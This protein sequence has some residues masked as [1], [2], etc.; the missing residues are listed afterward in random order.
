MAINGIEQKVIDIFKRVHQCIAE[1]YQCDLEW[2]ERPK[3]LRYEAGGRFDA[4]W[5]AGFWDHNK[6]RLTELTIEIISH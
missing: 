4:H 3:I 5:D 2:F 1:F 6:S